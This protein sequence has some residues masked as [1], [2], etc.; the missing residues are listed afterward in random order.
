[1]VNNKHTGRFKLL[2]GFPSV[3]E[4][5]DHFED[6]VECNAIE[7]NANNTQHALS[8]TVVNTVRFIEGFNPITWSLRYNLA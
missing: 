6:C 1:M 8:Y 2:P 3:C 5:F 4:M 7:R